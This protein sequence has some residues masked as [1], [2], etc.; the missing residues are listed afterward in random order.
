MQDN[1]VSLLN[2]FTFPFVAQSTLGDHVIIKGL[3][4]KRWSDSRSDFFAGSMSLLYNQE[5]SRKNASSMTGWVMR[6]T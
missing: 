1:V 4:Q 5:L 3:L 6:V 2:I